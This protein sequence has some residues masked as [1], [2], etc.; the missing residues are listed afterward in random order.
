MLQ[1]WAEKKKKECLDMD[2][3]V[4]NKLSISEER[5]GLAGPVKCPGG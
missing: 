1:A 4:G 5:D 3:R 2:K